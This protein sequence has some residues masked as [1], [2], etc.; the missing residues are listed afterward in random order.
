MQKRFS[1][2]LTPT[3][4]KLLDTLNI[5]NI[6][7][8]Y[9]KL[10]P[11]VHKLSSTASPQNLQQLTGRPIITAHSWTTSNI[12]K[13]LASELDNL[14]LK[15]KHLFISHNFPF[16][17][18][19]N[20][21]ELI[22][23]LQQQHI[24]D[25]NQFSF[26][27]FDFSSLYTNIS[28]QNT[29]N[30]IISCCKLLHLPTLYRDFLL[31]LNDFINNRNFF[32]AGQHIYQ[33]IH[34]IAMGSYHSRQMA[35]LVLLLCEFNFYTNNNSFKPHILSRYIDDGFLFNNITHSQNIIDNLLSF[36][37]TQI[38]VTF[39]SNLHSVHYLDL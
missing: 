39:T 8:P 20:S 34:G 31:N 30:A 35:D 15:L 9:L 1:P 6:Q 17:I 10:L 23:L 4:R 16:P 19:Q 32:S 25:I 28:F 7:I 3:K 11:K 14:I 38:P 36:Y 13:L 26:T 37:P 27:T 18:I 2:S 12:S 5:D 29:N 22:H 24:S 33:Q 21:F